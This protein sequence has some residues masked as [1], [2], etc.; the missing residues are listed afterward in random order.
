MFAEESWQSGPR[1][2]LRS[3]MLLWVFFEKRNASQQLQLERYLIAI[4]DS[5]LSIWPG[6][7]TDINLNSVVDAWR[8]AKDLGGG[9]SAPHRSFS[10]GEINPAN[11][12]P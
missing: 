1:R 9:S 10:P 4:L 11:P 6:V 3:C 8:P 7:G 2:T 12:K 5:V